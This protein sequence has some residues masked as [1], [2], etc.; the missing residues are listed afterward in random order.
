LDTLAGQKPEAT[1]FEILQDF[2]LETKTPA[3]P[4]QFDGSL[5]C[6]SIN[7]SWP[8]FAVPI[9]FENFTEQVEQA[10]A[11]AGPKL[12]ARAAV[13]ETKLLVRCEDET[14]RT[15]TNGE[16]YLPCIGTDWSTMTNYKTETDFVIRSVRNE[17]GYPYNNKRQTEFRLRKNDGMVPFAMSQD[18]G[19]R[20]V[21]IAYGYCFP[22]TG[23]PK[24]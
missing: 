20:N 19:N 11:A 13:Y 16:P 14:R 8:E 6:V 23:S 17:Q 1:R 18:V 3:E 9:R 2:Y 4:A 24:Q 15:P 21:G 22:S 7:A 10:Q 12:P 5:E